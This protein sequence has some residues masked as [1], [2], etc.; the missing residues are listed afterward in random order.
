MV[1]PELSRLEYKLEDLVDQARMSVDERNRTLR[2]DIKPIPS[3]ERDLEKT[4]TATV[5]SIAELRDVVLDNNKPADS[6][7]RNE[8]LERFTANYN[9]ILQQYKHDP[10][11]KTSF[12]ELTLERPQ[13]KPKH[14]RFRD[15]LVDIKNYNPAHSSSAA[16]SAE[17][18]A[19]T[20][21]ASASDN[22]NGGSQGVRSMLFSQQ[23]YSDD[24]STQ[25]YH[26]SDD[27]DDSDGSGP[28]L[29]RVDTNN[30]QHL[31]QQQLVLDEQDQHL[32]R[33]AASVSRQHMLSLHIGDE[34]ETHLD[35]LDEVHEFADRSHNRLAT[36][37]K[38]LTKFSK[39]AR[40]N[41][42]ILTIAILFIIFII[43]LIVLK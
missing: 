14:V 16:G 6:K 13:A 8:L 40:E 21:G 22:S 11:L 27:S 19:T 25:S 36:A 12:K 42:S 33:L 30:H 43:L 3:S 10:N 20:A 26:D 18:A 5:E 37:K 31:R 2:L 15:N 41:G 38:R 4:L 17:P 7:R 9:E 23:P 28:L 35:L 34:L 24:P 1:L 29:P 39:K 32:D